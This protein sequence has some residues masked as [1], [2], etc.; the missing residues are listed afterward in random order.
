MAPEAEAL[1]WG[2]GGIAGGS[3]VFGG[4]SDGR[5]WHGTAKQ[6]FSARRMDTETFAK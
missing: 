6:K 1:A 4:F 2:W 5:S 3:T